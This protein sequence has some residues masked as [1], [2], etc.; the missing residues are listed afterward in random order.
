MTWRM[1]VHDPRAPGCNCLDC[2][3]AWLADGAPDPPW[4]SPPAGPAPA[5][6]PGPGEVGRKQSAREPPVE[7]PSE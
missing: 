5:A 2:L 6:P 7:D 4:L 3:W 1:Y